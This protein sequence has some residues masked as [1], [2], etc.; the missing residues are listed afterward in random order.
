MM[1]Y[2]EIKEAMSGRIGSKYLG[3]KEMKELPNILLKGETP[4]QA[5]RGSRESDT[6]FGMLVATDQRL[7]FIYKGFMSLGIE[8]FPYD[9]I[10]SV[11]YKTG[12]ASGDI[13]IHGSGNRVKIANIVNEECAPFVD[14]V[15]NYMNEYKS[16]APT[17]KSAPVIEAAED[18][19][20]KVIKQLKELGELKN[21]GILTEEE[22]QSEK[23]KILST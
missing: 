18:R 10:T 23:A 17:R 6:W 5:V 12:W 16:D 15:R 2:E 14:W 7:I 4:H 21:Q 3:K 13:V 1:D 9:K 8:D 20:D 11:E 19:T 22:F